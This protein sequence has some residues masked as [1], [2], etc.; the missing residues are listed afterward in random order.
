MKQ[1]GLHVFAAI[2]ALSLTLNAKAQSTGNLQLEDR[3][4]RQ[5]HH[6]LVMLPQ[7]TIFDNL[8]YKVDGT[9]VTL[10]GEVR[11]AYLKDAAANSVKRIE[12]VTQVNNQ[13]A[14]LPPSPNDDRIR[15]QTARALFRDSRLFRY[16]MGSLPPIRIIVNGGHVTLVGMVDNQG[17]KNVAGIRANEVP[18]VFSVTNDLRVAD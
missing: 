1:F 5:V 15:R 14:I 3:I 17:D 10:L 7:L 12:G 11:T 9:S 16:S 2:L 18:G 8:A 6:E 4:N 13:I